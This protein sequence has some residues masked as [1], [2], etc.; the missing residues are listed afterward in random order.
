MKATSHSFVSLAYLPIPKFLDVGSDLQATLSMRVYHLC[1]DIFTS[2]LKRAERVGHLMPDGSGTVRFCF[3]PLVSHIMDL[4]E[5]RQAAIVLTNQSPTSTA[6]YHLFGDAAQCPPRTRQHTLNLINQ[7]CL[8]ADPN[9]LEA[10]TREAGRLGLL[11]VHEPYWRDWGQAEPSLFLTPDALHAWHKFFFD[12]VI[13][14]VINMISGDE[15]DRRLQALPINVGVRHWKHGVSKLKQV[16]GREHRDLEK[17]IVPVIAGAVSAD[18]LCSIRAL[19]EFIFHV[20]GLLIYDDHKHTIDQALLEFHNYKNEIIKAGG[21]HGKRGAILHFKIPKLEGM[22][23]VTYNTAYMGAPYQ[24]TSDITERCHITHVKQPYRQSNRRNFSEQIAR[25]MDRL[26]KVAQ[27]DLYTRLKRHGVSLLNVMVEEAS[28]VANHYPEATWLSHVLPQDEHQ[29]HGAASRPSLFQKTRSRL[30]DDQSTAFLVAC[31]PHHTSSWISQAST[32]FKVP[33]LRAAL[34]DY[35]DRDH[36]RLSS[37]HLAFE[38]IHIWNS[39]RIQQRSSQDRTILLPVRTLQALP[40]SAELPTGRC[41]TV[42]I[43]D[44]ISGSPTR[45][46]DGQREFLSTTCIS[47]E[48]TFTQVI[49][50]DRCE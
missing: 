2:S 4:A 31:K 47:Y 29:V 6:S 33:E 39:L 23:R 22:G 9:D 3:T 26:E 20:Q 37:Y 18:V 36:S 45:D 30:S 48:L 5:Q 19:V 44:N 11:G 24:Y 25:F 12:H 46:S 13:T 21:R 17:L 15:L 1:F 35:F 40:P 10:Y 41:N 43:T 14:W 38:K 32:Q 42:L 7:A 8:R 27:F 16:T 28:E 50:L 49:A 34:V